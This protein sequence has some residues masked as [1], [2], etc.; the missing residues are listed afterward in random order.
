MT[1]KTATLIGFSAVILWSLLAV[2]TVGSAPMPPLQLNAICFAIS[3]LI[4]VIWVA[5]GIGFAALWAI[6]WKIYAFGTV[7]LFG[8]HFLYFSALRLAPPAEA[9]LIAYLWPL[10]IVL[11]SGLLPEEHLRPAHILGAGLGFTGAALLIGSGADLNAASLPGYGLAL[12]CAFTW[13]GYSVISRRLGSAPTETVAVFCLL[14]AVLST[15]AHIAF[16]TA[17]WPQTYAG[18]GAVLGLGLGP[19]GLAFYTWDIGMKKGDI[20]LLGVASYA[21]PVLSTLV[22]VGVG[23][24]QASW[25]LVVAAALISAGA[26]LTARASTAKGRSDG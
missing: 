16:E 17:Y 26:A 10:L 20:Q 24:A 11:F 4:G 3:G 7:G 19:V 5:R 12:L 14:S 18:W 2:L 8:Y 1:R 13:A 9:G 22:L 6:N 15:S 25:P 21:A 23:I